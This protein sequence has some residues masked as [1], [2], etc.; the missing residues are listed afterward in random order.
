[1]KEVICA[2]CGKN[3]YDVDIEYLIGGNHLSCVLMDQLSDAIDKEEKA[4]KKKPM[5]I[6]NWTKL[7]GQK[8]DVMGASFVIMDTSEPGLSDGTI[9]T[10]WIHAINDNEPFVR[11]TLFSNDM[12]LQIKVLPPADYDSSMT[13][14]ELTTTM[15]KTHLSNPS[16]FVQTIAEGLTDDPS[17]RDIIQFVGRK[18]DLNRRKKGTGYS[19]GAGI[20]GSSGNNLW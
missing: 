6:K 11:V 8:F 19:P 9:Y 1:M 14:I 10:A 18:Q 7:T 15:T 17:V 20:S 2:Y 4:K 16:I 3:T 5:E 12:H 13:P